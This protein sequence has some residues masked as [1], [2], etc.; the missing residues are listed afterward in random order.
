MGA[1][2]LP[3]GTPAPAASAPP[4]APAPPPPVAPARTPAP[5]VPVRPV[6]TAPRKKGSPWLVPVLVVVAIA[7]AAVLYFLF[8]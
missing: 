2:Q 7:A 4:R 1:I 5:R 8:R 6:F 3:Q